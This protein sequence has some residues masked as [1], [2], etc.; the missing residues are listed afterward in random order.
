MKKISRRQSLAIAASLP[1]I[2]ATGA[3]SLLA[4]SSDTPIIIS[5]GSLKMRSGVPWARFAR[6]GA[7]RRLH[8][9]AGKRITAVEV[10]LAGDN[11]TTIDFDAQQCE[12]FLTYASID[13]VLTTGR[14]GRGL[15]IDTDWDAFR[16]GSSENEL[17]HS[18]QQS[19]ISRVIVSRDDVTVLD[20]SPGGGTRIILR[21]QD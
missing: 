7:R 1:A 3:G 18:N 4:Q 9:S 19:K 17:E 20:Q 21:Y 15:R 12:V 5:D 16:D 13:I 8:P 2:A 10:R 6:Q 11:N 14:R